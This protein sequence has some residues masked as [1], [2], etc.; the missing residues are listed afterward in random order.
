M[1]FQPIRVGALLKLPPEEVKGFFHRGESCGT[2]VVRTK[3]R[4]EIPEGTQCH[5]ALHGNSHV[6]VSDQDGVVL[7][8]LLPEA[9]F[10]LDLEVAGYLPRLR[11]NLRN[12]AWEQ[13]RD[14]L[15]LR[16]TNPQDA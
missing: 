6:L 14:Q 10:Y 4:W 15:V 3:E 1:R 2:A 13:T 5:V 11:V 16:A 8:G 9:R 12:T 7:A